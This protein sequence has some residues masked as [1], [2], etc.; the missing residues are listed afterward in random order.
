M[1][2]LPDLRDK[3]ILFV[4]AGAASFETIA[5]MRAL[6]ARGA[7][8]AFRF[9]DGVCEPRSARLIA[10][11]ANCAF[12]EEARPSH[13]DL[14]VVALCRLD[15]MRQM[16]RS[17]SLQ[18]AHETV[19]LASTP[20]VYYPA[21]VSAGESGAAPD[22]EWPPGHVI[23][24]LHRHSAEDE[25]DL[26]RACL[27]PKILRGRRVLVT[28][29]PTFEAIDPVR[30]ITNHSSG[31]MGFAVA[32]AACMAGAQVT[33]VAGPVPLR[34]PVGVV[35][36]DVVSARE[37]ADACAEAAEG[38]DIFVAAAAV[39]DW[40]P[41][42]PSLTKLKKQS[43]P[44][45]IELV[46]NPDILRAIATSPRAL[47][48]ALYCVGFAAETD[49]LLANAAVKLHK[50]NVPLLVANIG[51]LAFGSE[52]N[53]VVVMDGRASIALPRASKHEIAQRLIEIIAARAAVHGARNPKPC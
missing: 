20:V 36:V 42:S 46:E 38:A 50:K 26:L 32:A 9:A 34:T 43:S 12:D 21:R 48:G 47:S 6:T 11:L 45:T 4:L 2:G 7:R 3:H 49:N 10:S 28:A 39:A 13:W 40:R 51:P 31:K 1:N 41:Q 14:V 23:G 52:D 35:R 8:I 5:L 27:V 44:P 29:G 37:M 18:L 16:A 30:G 22:R 17:G 19:S 25:C 24:D 33:L 15:D 53:E